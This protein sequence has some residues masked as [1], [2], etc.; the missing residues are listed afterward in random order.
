M[1]P[2]DSTM[3]SLLPLIL[4]CRASSGN[5]RSRRLHW[6]SVDIGFMKRVRPKKN[7]RDCGKVQRNVGVLTL[8]MHSFE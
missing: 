8:P 3:Q 7:D 2:A 4:C 1:P 5:D 6:N